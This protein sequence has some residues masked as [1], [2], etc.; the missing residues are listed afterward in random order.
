MVVEMH[1]LAQDLED[2]RMRAAHRLED[3]GA[4]G[5]QAVA[6]EA[7]LV[8]LHLQQV[9]VLALRLPLAQGGGHAASRLAHAELAVAVRRRLPQARDPASAILLW[10]HGS[11]LLPL[12]HALTGVGGVQCFVLLCT[13]ECHRNQ[14]IQET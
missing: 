10:P 7:V 6:D 14:G 13:F 3:E 12:I 2:L 5:V 9:A 4:H 1:L 8:R 11:G